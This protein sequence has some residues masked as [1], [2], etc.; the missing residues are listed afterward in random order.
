VQVSE[1]AGLITA[2]VAF[3]GAIGAAFKFVWDKIERR[4]AH[5]ER[6]LEQCRKGREVKTIV[7][8]LLWRGLEKLE[9]DC[10]ELVRA[11]ALLD[12]LKLEE[13]RD[14]LDM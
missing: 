12:G 8:E 7:I 11:K 5:I 4:F 3:V 6:H 10:A 1:L 13:A 14:R 2:I 9:P